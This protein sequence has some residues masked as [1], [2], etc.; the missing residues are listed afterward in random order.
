MWVFKWL[1]APVATVLAL[2]IGAVAIGPAVAAAEG[3]G[4]PGYFVAKV[5][6]CIKG[7]CSWTGDFVAS[8]GKVVRHNVSFT[9]PHGTL[10]KGARLPAL[11]TGGAGT[12]Y[13]R[14][15]SHDWIGDLATIVVAGIGFGLWAWRVPYR[16]LRRRVRGDAFLLPNA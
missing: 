12:V 1:I 10:Y 16:K 4:T 9:G 7:R 6:Q 3:H 2:I 5:E 8:D 15:G 14:H 13:A 11:D